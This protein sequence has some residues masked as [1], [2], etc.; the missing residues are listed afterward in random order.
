MDAAEKVIVLRSRAL[1]NKLEAYPPNGITEMDIEDKIYLAKAKEIDRILE[2]VLDQV[3][4]NMTSNSI[5]PL[6]HGESEA[7]PSLK[8][9]KVEAMERANTI[10]ESESAQSKRSE[11]DKAVLKAKS[12]YDNVM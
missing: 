10:A 3:K 4:R 12:I 8:R 6:A 2:D 5:A 9:R 1:A 7:E 11:R